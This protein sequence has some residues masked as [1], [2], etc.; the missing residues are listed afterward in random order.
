M[1]PLFFKF[2][3]YTNNYNDYYYSYLEKFCLKIEKIKG[4]K[5]LLKA[6]FV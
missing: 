6:N 3:H 4:L 2:V 1:Q 5:Q